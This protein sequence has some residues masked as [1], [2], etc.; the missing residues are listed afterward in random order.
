MKLGS[1]THFSISFVFAGRE[2]WYESDRLKTELVVIFKHSS[3]TVH[4]HR[5]S[6]VTFL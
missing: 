5:S 4:P 3:V 2:S 1:I 6:F